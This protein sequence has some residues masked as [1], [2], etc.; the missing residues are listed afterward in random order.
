MLIESVVADQAET[1][2]FVAG[3]RGAEHLWTIDRESGEN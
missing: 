2:W 1:V 3:Y